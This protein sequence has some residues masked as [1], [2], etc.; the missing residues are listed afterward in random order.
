MSSPDTS[1][2]DPLLIRLERVLAECLRRPYHFK[3]NDVIALERLRHHDIP[4]DWIV[5]NTS[6]VVAERHNTPIH[7]FGYIALVLED[8][9]KG[10]VQR[11]DT[12]PR[13]KPRHSPSHA[14]SSKVSKP[15]KDPRYEAFYALFPE[16][17]QPTPAVSESTHSGDD[18]YANFYKLFPEEKTRLS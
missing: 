10:R 6:N 12:T 16:D 17:S 2:S 15:E 7:C 4:D 9:W 8:W 11:S 3:P 1:V 13:I 5:Q 18:R 14:R